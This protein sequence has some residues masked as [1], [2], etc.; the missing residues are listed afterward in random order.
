MSAETVRPALTAQE[1][2]KREFSRVGEIGE[3]ARAYFLDERGLSLEYGDGI[4]AWVGVNENALHPLA[5]FCLHG[6]PFGFTREDVWHLRALLA[7]NA[8][9]DTARTRTRDLANR[10]AALLPPEE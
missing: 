8:L 10:I 6:Q 1:W 3:A 7:V 2:K 9:D 5:A 4:D